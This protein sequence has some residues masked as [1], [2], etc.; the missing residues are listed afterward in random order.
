RAVGDRDARVLDQVGELDAEVVG[1]A[2]APLVAR[3]HVALIRGLEPRGRGR[4]RREAG[5]R[6]VHGDRRVAED[7]RQQTVG[8]GA[9]AA[10]DEVVPGGEQRVV[11]GAVAQRVG[12]G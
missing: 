8:G 3:E 9:G 11:G 1:V 4:G 6:Q 5:V 10:G 12:G 7:P 2:R